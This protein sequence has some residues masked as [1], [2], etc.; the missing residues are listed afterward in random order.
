MEVIT[1][2]LN[3]DFDGLASM[4]MA[5]KLYP[6]AVPVFAGSQEKSVRDFFAQSTE[7]FQFQRLRDIP[8]AEVTRLILVDTRQPSRIGNFAQCLDNPGLEIHIFDH[9]PDAPGDLRGDYQV[10]KQVGS[11]AT[12][13]IEIFRERQIALST[14]DA[15]LLAMAIHEDTGSFTFETTTPADLMAMAWLL[16]QGANPHA[17]TQFIA[18]ELTAQQVAVLHELI[19]SATT[20][21]IQG[22]DIVVA[23]IT[24]PEYIDEL[25]VLV[26]RFMVMEN[27]NVLFALAAME[28]RIY[29]IARS[30]IP[31]VNVGKMAREL[32]GGGHASA[33]SATLKG[34]T[35]IEAEEKLLHLLHKH[36][37]PQ[38]LAREL[39]SAPVISVAPEVTILDA[40]HLLTR[41]NIT[42]MPVL[43][44]HHELLGL[45]SRRV[46]EKAIHHGLGD[47]AVSEYMSTEFATL[48]PEATLA[49]I[50]ELLIEHRQ[51]VIPV[52]ENDTVVGVIT[53][54]DLLSMLVNDP[55]HTPKELLYTP[56]HSAM[57]RHRNLNTQLVASLDRDTIL[58]LR[59]VGEVASVNHFTAFAVGGFVRDLLLHIPNFDIDV[60]VEG[61]GIGF[62]KELAK[63]LD[64]EV[65]THD[66]F[67]TAVVLLAGG[68]KVDVATARLE[69]YEYP[70]AMPTVEL[71]SI[72]LD[73]SRRDFTI[74]AMAI[75]LNPNRF[76][77]LVDF[78][79]SQNDLKERQLRVL[80]N[81]SFVE[82]PTRIFRAIRFEQR[83][84]FRLGKHTERLIQGAVRMNL[85]GR[86]RGRRFFNELRLIL[87]EAQPLEAIRQLA[88]FDL[89][90][91]LHPAIK[92]DRPL[93]A[94]LDETG[95]S[96]DWHRLLYLDEPCQYWLVYLLGLLTRITGKQAAAFCD[97]FEVPERTRRLILQEKS[98]ARKVENA[99]DRRPDLPASRIYSLLKGLGPEGLL[100]LMSATR[101]TEVKKAVSWY[102]TQLRHVRIKT[103]GNR[104][105]QMGYPEGP[106]Y[107]TILDRLLAVKLDGKVKS[108][109]DETAFIRS[110]YPLP[111][112]AR[113]AP[114]GT[115]HPCGPTPRPKPHRPGKD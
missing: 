40:N 42:V 48:P 114:D 79:N 80:H 84:G 34:S 64:G 54:T 24:L 106:L 72:K 26:R 66:K 53:R 4:V 75:H 10:I 11:T 68:K 33:A 13:L 73:L 105:K 49:D 78:F 18:Q 62:A 3:A 82:D 89:I 65:R 103:N 63:R 21:T 71:S 30:R 5:R 100:H 31:E 47:L 29:L 112:T 28:S 51:R 111:K 6:H 102:V 56:N 77:L 52:V 81:L 90:R 104:L 25:A 39:M 88:R 101:Q 96:I 55:A 87:D 115:Q 41:Y 93:R 76:G 85:F 98:T 83:M 38:S 50:Q 58:L 95:S 1:T 113:P 15:T 74:N 108:S 91:F 7:V 9:H 69:Y 20:Y 67:N 46:I 44:D 27:L 37:R 36:V 32:G 16:E 59:A 94:V 110:H 97:R 86:C 12:I 17:V 43:K 70:A 8:L 23:K 22:L 14:D 60:V 35:I 2:H 57:E 19:K 92:F 107:R 109:A 99:F 61:D 45:I